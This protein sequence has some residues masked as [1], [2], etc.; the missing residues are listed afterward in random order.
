MRPLL[1]AHFVDIFGFYKPIY[2]IIIRNLQNLPC[3]RIHLR[4]HSSPRNLSD[5]KDTLRS[6]DTLCT[7]KRMN[8][9]V[10]QYNL[11]DTRIVLPNRPPGC[12]IQC[13]PGNDNRRADMGHQRL[14]VFLVVENSR[15]CI[16]RSLCLLYVPEKKIIIIFIRALSYLQGR[17][18]WCPTETFSSN[19]MGKLKLQSLSLLLELVSS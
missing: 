11:A 5:R 4:S 8:R 6:S 14:E 9:I 18:T 12:R 1:V 7:Q 10:H 2:N 13:L 3:T 16:V 19:Y 15:V 17:Y